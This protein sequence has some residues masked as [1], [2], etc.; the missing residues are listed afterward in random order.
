MGVLLIVM[1]VVVIVC[2]RKRKLDNLYKAPYV[3]TY[4]E[5]D[6]SKEKKGDITEEDTVLI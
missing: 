5:N 1:I 6:Q 4:K 2:L 3:P